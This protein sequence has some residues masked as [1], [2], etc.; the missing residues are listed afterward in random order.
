MKKVIIITGPGGVGKTTVAKLIE[1]ECGY[2]FLDGDNEDTEFFPDGGQWMAEN[3]DKLEKAHN[4][5][6]NKAKELVCNG[7]KV[8]VDYIV[9]GHYA[10][11]FSKFRKAFGNDLQI[12]VLFPKQSKIITR[13]RERECWT[14]GIDRIK[15]VCCEF[16]KHR[17]EVGE[18]NYIDTS[19][20]T[21]EETFEKYF[22]C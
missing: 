7:E 13:D 15:A 11:F 19:G 12:A 3:T 2:V 4:K 22:K 17:D 6:L 18:E 14:T 5:I 16:E 9:F 10:E 1:K 21:P 20:Q 8:V